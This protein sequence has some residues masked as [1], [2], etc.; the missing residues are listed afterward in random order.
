MK[1]FLLSFAFVFTLLGIAATSAPRA[2][3][4]DVNAFT[5]QEYTVDYYLGRDTEGRSTL[6]TVE[7]IRAIFPQ[8]NQNHGLER[9]LPTVY[10]GHAT[11]LRVTAVT[12]QRNKALQYSSRTSGNNQV[13]RI[14][15]PDTYVHG[16]QT[17]R[18]TY[19]Q[20]DVTRFFK[21]TG[22][23]EFYWD[24]NGTEWAV[25]IQSLRATVH[26]DDKLRGKLTSKQACYIGVAGATSSCE[27][28]K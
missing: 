2:A 16:D 10:D 26:L 27:V 19:T 22:A 28:T 21:D 20:R 9:A 24:T 25:P 17:Y 7:V 18:I 15:N 14:G 5:I 13:L 6:K 11:G 3:A 4:A 1:K 12:D 23:D 8:T